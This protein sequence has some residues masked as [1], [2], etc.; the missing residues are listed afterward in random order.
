MSNTLLSFTASIRLSLTHTFIHDRST[1][2]SKCTWYETGHTCSAA[3]LS[4]SL[5]SADATQTSCEHNYKVSA[6]QVSTHPDDGMTRR[7]FPSLLFVNCK[8]MCVLYIYFRT[9]MPLHYW[10]I[11][12]PVEIL[13]DCL[14]NATIKRMLLFYMLGEVNWAHLHCECSHL[15][16]IDE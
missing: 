1:K 15:Q 12:T 11:S 3:K 2:K 10:L 7:D 13:G 9:A 14:K 6:Y 16:C 8:R 5:T 4:A